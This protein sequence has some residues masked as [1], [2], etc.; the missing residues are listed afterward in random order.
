MCLV[1]SASKSTR[2]N[3]KKGHGGNYMIKGLA[4]LLLA[5]SVSFAGSHV[6]FQSGRLLSVDKDER[7]Y[8]GTS[9][10]WAEYEWGHIVYPARGERL[11]RRTSPGRGLIIGDEVQ[12]AVD[13]DKLIIKRPDGKQTKARTM[14]RERLGAK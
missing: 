9:V 8:E 14:K 13:R 7:L 4:F 10:R 1:V 6:D 2:R 5:V 11:R 3:T 12:I